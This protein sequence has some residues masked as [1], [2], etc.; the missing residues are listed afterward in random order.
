MNF[1]WDEEKRQA[2]LVKHGIDFEDAQDLFDGREIIEVE[3]DY[4]LEVRRKRTGYVND[5]LVTAIWTLRG[6][7]IRFISVRS[8]RDVEKQEYRQVYG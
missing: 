6:D 3:S 7:A 2:N 4:P 1:E 5:R 8:A